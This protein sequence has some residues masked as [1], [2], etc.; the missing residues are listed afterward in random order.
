LPATI[1]VRRGALTLLTTHLRSEAETRVFITENAEDTKAEI[2][3]REHSDHRGQRVEEG[4]AEESTVPQLTRETG[5]TD[6]LSSRRSP[7]P[8][9]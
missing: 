8:L 1:G 9:S 3:H 4:V 7:C 5:L 6:G 2:H